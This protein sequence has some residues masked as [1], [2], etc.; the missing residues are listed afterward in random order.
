MR[1]SLRWSSLAGA[2]CLIVSTFCRAEIIND[3]GDIEVDSPPP[4]LIRHAWESS[5]NIRVFAEKTALT[6]TAEVPVDFSQAGRIY[7]DTRDFTPSTIVPGT[8]VDSYLLHVD[9]TRQESYRYRGSVTFAEEIIGI[10]VKW[11]GL[12]ATTSVFGLPETRYDARPGH[13]IEIGRDKLDWG[14]DRRTLTFFGHASPRIDQVRVL[15]T[16][17]PGPG[18][19]LMAVVGLMIGLGLST[20]RHRHVK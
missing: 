2:G 19:A 15:T 11:Q 8:M 1:G 13:G 17:I 14:T 7:Q 3:A 6:V 5:E 18:S 16:P 20:E 9:P 12:K 10:I 4:S